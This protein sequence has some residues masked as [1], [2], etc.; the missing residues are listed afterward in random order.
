MDRTVPW[1]RRE[2]LQAALTTSVGA[3]ALLATAGAY[4][5]G[6]ELVWIIAAVALWGLTIW[7]W[8]R[9][10]DWARSAPDSPR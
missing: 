8:R 4:G 3:F 5:G 9:L 6:G 10:G 1:I 2:Q 7:T